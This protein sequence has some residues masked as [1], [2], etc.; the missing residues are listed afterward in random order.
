MVE[1]RSATL[2]PG[3]TL[4]SGDR[5]KK[6]ALIGLARASAMQHPKATRTAAPVEQDATGTPATLP[7]STP[8]APAPAVPQPDPEQDQAIASTLASAPAG[9]AARVG[10]AVKMPPPAPGEGIEEPPLGTGMGTFSGG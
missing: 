9:P 7:P 5:L 4:P 8:A 2:P 6:M 1:P 3:F 10:K